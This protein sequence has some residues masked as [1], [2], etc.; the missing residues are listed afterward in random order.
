MSRW[1]VTEETGN[2]GKAGCCVPFVSEELDCMELAVGDNMVEG[3]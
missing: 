1:M 3:L 2:A